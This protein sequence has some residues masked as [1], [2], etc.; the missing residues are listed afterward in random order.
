[1]L[2]F[3]KVTLFILSDFI[4][5]VIIKEVEILFINWNTT[6][7]NDKGDLHVHDRTKQNKNSGSQCTIYYFNVSG[8]NVYQY[9]AAADG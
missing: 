5:L 7:W 4:I 6:T 9:Q 8:Y 3:E 1:M 2:F